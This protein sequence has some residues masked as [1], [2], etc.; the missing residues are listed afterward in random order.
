MVNIFLVGFMGAGKTSI[1]R[2]LA[3]HLGARFLDL[4][5]RISRDFACPIPEIFQKRGEAAFRATEAEALRQLCAKDGLVVATGGGAFSSAGNREM[6]ERSGG[7]SVYL[8]V[9]WAVLHRRLELD[10]TDRPV[11][12]DADQARALYEE[13]LPDYRRATISVALSGE[14]TP[15]EAARSVA[16]AVTGVVCAI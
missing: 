7:I 5:E 11:Y 12:R 9:P 10:N 13:R 6:I 14:E 3:A 2:Q 1:G 4:D 8:D 16:R 15:D